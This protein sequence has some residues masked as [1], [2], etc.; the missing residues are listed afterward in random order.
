MVKKLAHI[1]LRKS[2]GLN[3]SAVSAGKI[4]S[5]NFRIKKK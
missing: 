2:A 3:L 1:D 4:F 5:V